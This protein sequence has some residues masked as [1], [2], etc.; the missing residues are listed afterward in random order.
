MEL[1]VDVADVGVGHQRVDVPLGVGRHPL[2]LVGVEEVD[3]E[4]GAVALSLLGR[5]AALWREGRE[6]KRGFNSVRAFCGV[7]K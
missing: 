1:A 7:C 6:R 4:D 2:E 5:G 3:A